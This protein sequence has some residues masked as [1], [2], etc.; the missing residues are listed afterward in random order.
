MMPATSVAAWLRQMNETWIPSPP[1]SS[2]FSEPGEDGNMGVG[3]TLRQLKPFANG[4]LDGL[5]ADAVEVLD[6]QTNERNLD[7]KSAELK[8]LLGTWRDRLPNL[9]DDINT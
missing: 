5:V 8:L 4:E 9:W 1:S 2:C 3:D 7:T 6:I